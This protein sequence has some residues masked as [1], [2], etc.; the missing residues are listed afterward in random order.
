M[1]KLIK[2]EIIDNEKY[3]KY[4]TDGGYNLA[5][6]KAVEEYIHH[7]PVHKTPEY[8]EWAIEKRHGI[9]NGS[10][11]RY[12]CKISKAGLI[13]KTYVNKKEPTLE[14][15]RQK[16]LRQMR[17]Y[18]KTLSSD[19]LIKILKQDREWAPK[20]NESFENWIKRLGNNNG[21]V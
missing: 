18:I 2:V 4:W 15:I 10:I 13:K 16:L 7:V 9:S 8:W 5:I 17:K 6:K 14:E 19:E 1:Q 3:E 11:N 12:F 21:S 20:Q